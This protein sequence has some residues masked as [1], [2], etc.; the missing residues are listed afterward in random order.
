LDWSDRSDRD[1]LAKRDKRAYFDFGASRDGFDSNFG[2]F[3]YFDFKIFRDGFDFKAFYF[4]YDN[5]GLGF[6]NVSDLFDDRRNLQSFYV[7]KRND[8]R[9]GKSYS[10][11]LYGS[12]RVFKRFD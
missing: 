11:K 7:D 6:R 4:F 3:R 10:F 5:V 12:L 1:K 9:R 2:I 8:G